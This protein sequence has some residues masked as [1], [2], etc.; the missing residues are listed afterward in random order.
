MAPKRRIP[1]IVAGPPGP[2]AAAAWRKGRTPVSQALESLDVGKSLIMVHATAQERG[3]ARSSA[4]YL[5]K[6]LGRRYA[7]RLV[8]TNG[9]EEFIIWRT[10]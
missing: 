7:T 6:K 8:V 3:R 4:A 1:K 5:Q 2:P 10:A 9:A